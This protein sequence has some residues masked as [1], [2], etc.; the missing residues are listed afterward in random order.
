MWRSLIRKKL[1]Y[2]YNILPDDYK[3]ITQI[4][5]NS[6]P[7]VYILII[8]KVLFMQNLT[9]KIVKITK[10]MKKMILWIQILSVEEKELIIIPQRKI[11]TTTIV[12]KALTLRTEESKMV[13]QYN[14]NNKDN[15]NKDNK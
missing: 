4:N 15:S 10:P 3:N 8:S 5:L 1:K 9:K 12:T 11:N 6:D 13:N 7:N 14:N 2:L